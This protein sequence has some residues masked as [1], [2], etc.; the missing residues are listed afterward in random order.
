[1][2]MVRYIKRHS[3][4]ARITHDAFAIACILLFVSGLFIFIPPLASAIPA[5]TL[6]VIRIIHRVVGF[7]FIA[8]PIVSAIRSPKGFKRFMG[9]YFHRWDNDDVV[10]LKR[11][12]PYMLAPKK[13][14]M[15][16]QHEMKSGQV[17]ADGALILGALVMGISGV[18]LVIGTAGVDL[19]AGFMLAIRL[20]HNIAFIWLIVFVIAHIFLGAGIF[21]PYR[22]TLRLMFGDGKVSE[23]DALYHW[24]YWAAEEFEKG[25]NIVEE[26]D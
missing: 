19:G 26:D 15:P 16:D 25:E 9:H 17:V 11:F 5:G 20:A 1:V 7:I 6:F 21:Q 10:W 8:I 2:I 12:V 24:G 23:S 4:Q 3:L 22:G 13:V 18:L 14:H